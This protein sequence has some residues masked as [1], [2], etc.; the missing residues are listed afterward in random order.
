M[1]K[2][3]KNLKIIV[4]VV[5]IVILIIVVAQARPPMQNKDQVQV[6]DGIDAPAPVAQMDQGVADAHPVPDRPE[7]VQVDSEIQI[8]QGIGNVYYI[9]YLTKATWLLNCTS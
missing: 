1:H 7:V 9:M 5:V 2:W 4:M 6:F 8:D 3:R